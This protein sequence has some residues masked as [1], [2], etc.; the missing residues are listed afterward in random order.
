MDKL[1]GGV[2]TCI[3]VGGKVEWIAG[4]RSTGKDGEDGFPELIDGFDFIDRGAANFC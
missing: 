3:V 2:L 4:E 1:G